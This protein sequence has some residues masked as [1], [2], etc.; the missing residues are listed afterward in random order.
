MFFYM[1]GV[2]FLKLI[3]IEIQHIFT[4][5]INIVTCTYIYWSS[6]L[7]FERKECERKVLKSTLT[8]KSQFI[9][10]HSIV[11]WVYFGVTCLTLEEF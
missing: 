10:F 9:L 2:E 8:G 1:Y 7:W 5:I 11:K 3:Y 4:S 6:V